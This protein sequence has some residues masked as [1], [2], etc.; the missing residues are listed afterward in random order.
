LLLLIHVQFPPSRV[1]AHLC[2]R[3]E[4]APA[5]SFSNTNAPVLQALGSGIRSRPA[6][7]ASAA[8]APG[9]R[10]SRGPRAFKRPPRSVRARGV[11]VAAVR[12][13][14]VVDASAIGVRASGHASSASARISLS[15]STTRSEVM[16]SASRNKRAD[17]RRTRRR[18]MLQGHAPGKLAERSVPVPSILFL[19]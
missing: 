7:L 9:Q 18:G 8:C 1:T 19:G 4:S 5:M 15:A 3:E 16:A 12:G 17:S 10:K 11:P 14:V 6:G 13:G 2:P